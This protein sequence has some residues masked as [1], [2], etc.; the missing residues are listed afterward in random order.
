M[1]V[2]AG[3]SPNFGAP[4]DGARPGHA[5]FEARAPRVPP[6]VGA[7]AGARAEAGHQSGRQGWL[8]EKINLGRRKASPATCARC[9]A[10]VLVG[11]DADVAAL[12]MTV[13][14]DPVGPA[15]ELRAWAAGRGSA[16]LIAG[17][18][19]RREPIHLTSATRRHRV[20]VEH[21]CP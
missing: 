4:T 9:G 16:D 7:R 17:E 11:L 19:H 12:T 15:D 21:R 10:P 3:K 18:L 5:S 6:Y 14:V 1:N 20:H 2:S 8:E 13:D